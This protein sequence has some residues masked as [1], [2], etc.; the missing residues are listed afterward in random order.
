MTPTPNRLW[1]ST[2]RMAS[3]WLNLWSVSATNTTGNSNPL[4]RCTVM[5]ET[6]P[7]R[8]WPPALWLKPPLAA[9]ASMARMSD[10]RPA[11]PAPAAQAVK[12][13]RS[14]RQRGPSGSAPTAAR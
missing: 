4:E 7:G 5:I 14:S 10:G 6:H 3:L 12:L 2:G 13:N 9:A 11:R 1:V 8:V